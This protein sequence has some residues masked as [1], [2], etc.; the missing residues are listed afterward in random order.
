MG[1]STAEMWRV[2]E[3]ALRKCGAYGEWRSR[4]VARMGNGAAEMWSIWEIAQRKCGAY[5]K[6]C[7]NVARMGNGAAEMWRIW[8]M[9]QRK[10]GAYRKWRSGNVAHMGNGAETMSRAYCA[11]KGSRKMV[12]TRLSVRCSFSNNTCRVIRSRRDFEGVPLFL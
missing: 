8:D 1:N 4:N 12:S 3:M 9:A 6:C 5:G 11:K 7:G 10:Y 2:W